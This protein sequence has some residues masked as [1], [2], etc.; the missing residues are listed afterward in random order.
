MLTAQAL[1]EEQ[2]TDFALGALEG[3]AW[4]EVSTEARALE[5]EL[6][7]EEGS[8]SQV[9]VASLATRELPGRPEVDLEQWKEEVNGNCARNCKTS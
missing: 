4:R 3:T 9:P 1:T 8:T 6:R 5:R 2:Q 7:G